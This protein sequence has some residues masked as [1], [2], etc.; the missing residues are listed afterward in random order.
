MK[1]YVL[2]GGVNGAGKTTLYQTNETYLNMP[3]I[4]MDEIV[5]EFGSW[6]VPAD[7]SKAGMIAV[8]KIKDYFEKGISFNLNF[9]RISD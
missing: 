6:R 3:R 4:N 9:L 8:R 1:R 5:R 7:V 2:F